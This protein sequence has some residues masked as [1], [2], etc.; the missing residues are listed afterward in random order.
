MYSSTMSKTIFSPDTDRMDHYGKNETQ[1]WSQADAS[2]YRACPL[3]VVSVP[4]YYTGVV[5]DSQLYTARK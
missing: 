2:V 3:A 4:A 5:A 1:N